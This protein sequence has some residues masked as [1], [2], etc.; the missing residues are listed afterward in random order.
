MRWD[1]FMAGGG[2]A[3]LSLAHRLAR[4]PL[5]DAPMAIADRHAKDDNDR[6]FASWSARP[7]PFDALATRTWRQLRLVTPDADIRLDL[8][9]F[10]YRVVRGLD[11]YRHVHDVLRQRRNVTLLQGEV[12]GVEDG[13]ELASVLVG[14]ELHQARWVFDSRTSP[15]CEEPVTRRYTYISQRFSGV[16][17]E[18]PDDAFDPDCP[19]FMDFRAPQVE[20]D[21]RFFYVLPY[22]ARRALVELV[23][24]DDLDEQTTIDSYL[25]Q[26]VG[27]GDWRAI[28]REGGRS[29]LTD[30]PFPRRVGQRILNIGARGGQIKPSTGYAFTRIQADSEAIANSLEQLGHPFGMLRVTWRYRLYD[31]LLLHI[32]QTRPALIPTLFGHL[33]RGNPAPRVLRFLDEH[34]SRLED[35]AIL[36]SVPPWPFLRAM[37]GLLWRRLAG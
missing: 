24:L 17:I 4:G 3:G 8:G 26:I 18:T 32:M 2:L 30:R 11:L 31:A 33:F 35:L 37:G 9:D 22:T 10:R 25:R 34:A 23:S 21:L 7:G 14:S 36:R 27:V 29:P 6:T 16:E 5:R 12:E 20:G 1:F 13:P 19:V 28:A 15:P